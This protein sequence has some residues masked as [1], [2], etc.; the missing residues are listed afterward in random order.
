MQYSKQAGSILAV[1]TGLLLP[2]VAYA[3]AG[4]Y[5]VAAFSVIVLFVLA[6]VAIVFL[7]FNF[8]R[9]ILILILF[10]IV[11]TS[12]FII[13]AIDTIDAFSTEMR[14]RW[15]YPIGTILLLSLTFILVVLPV[16]QYLK[17]NKAPQPTPKSGAAEL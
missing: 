17:P 9:S 16:R 13:G 15:F 4:A 14:S 6:V 5:L 3:F 7:Y 11:T 1:M 8:F 10:E 2:D 12:I